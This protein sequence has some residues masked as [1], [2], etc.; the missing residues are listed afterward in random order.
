M[1]Y[2]YET[3]ESEGKMDQFGKKVKAQK[4]FFFIS[5]VIKL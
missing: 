4:R 2:T 3:I 5:T 1:K